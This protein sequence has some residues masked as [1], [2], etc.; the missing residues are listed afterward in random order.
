[1]AA[2]ALLHDPQNEEKVFVH[3]RPRLATVGSDNGR[4]GVLR[5][6]YALFHK[7]RSR[8]NV[9]GRSKLGRN[10]DGKGVSAPSG[11]LKT[12]W[13]EIMDKERNRNCS[14]ERLRSFFVPKRK[15]QADE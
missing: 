5:G 7:Q 4:I 11:A 15:E 1:M 9:L 13:N 2:G 3:H 6:Y 14:W 10:S 12:T 8:K